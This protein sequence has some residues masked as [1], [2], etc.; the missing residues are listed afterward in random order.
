MWY[1]EGTIT[2]TQGSDALSGTGTYWNVTAN[3]V[4]P[5]MIVIGPDNKLYEIK[6]VI[7]DT[8]LILAEPYTG[9]TQTD[10]PCR[11]IT[12][13]EGDLTQ[14]SARFTAL[15]TRMSADSK[16]MR[17]WLTAVDEVTLEREDGT[18]VTVKSLTQIVDEHN[19]NQKWYTDNADVI[20]AAGDKAREA[21]ASAAAAAESANTA[22]TKATEAS[23]SAAAAAASENA[24]GASASAA[25]TSETNAESFKVE[26][27]A[28]AAT[29][30]TKATE[31]GESA[32][33]AAASKDAA[34]ASETQAATSASEASASASAASDSAAAAKTSETNAS[35]S[36]QAAAGSAADA[37]ASKNA[38]KESETHA[39]SSAGESAASA[40]A[41]KTSETNADASQKAAAASESAAAS[42]ANAASE[43]ATAA[44]E[45]ADAAL[46]SKNAAASSEQKAKTS[47][48]NAKASET[49]ASES[50]TAAEAS[51]AAAQNSEA[52]AVESAAAAAGSAD[53]ASKSATAAA[54]SATTATEKANVASEQA[55]ASE[56]SA[57]AAKTSETN[58]KS[59]ETAA[60]G[61]AT[62]A[63]KSAGEAAAS[64]TTA[65]EAMAVAEAKAKEA[66]D[67]AAL[68]STKATEAT[69]A[70]AGAKT[71]ELNAKESETKAYEYAQNAQASVASVKWKGTSAEMDMATDAPKWVKVS[72]ARMPQST[73][74]VYI[75]VIG[76][77][78]YE[79]GQP[80][81]AAMADIV[82]RTAAG[83]PKSLNAVAYRT[84]D[85]AVLTV[86]T[87]NTTD[88]NYDIYLKA[89]AGSQKLVVN[90]QSAGAV[91]ETLE[92][93]EVVDTLP[94]D[95]VEGT[96]YH[97]VISDQDGSI[98][99]SL[100]GNASTAT[101]LQT[102]RQIGGVRFDGSADINLPGVNIQGDQNTTGNAATA[103]KLQTPRTINSVMFDGSANITIPTLVSRGR[104]N[105]LASNTQGAMPGI[106][107][108]EAYNNSYPTA[109]GNVIHLK[110]AY[111]SGEGELLVG[112]SGTSG[113]H[114]PVYVR[115][116]RDAG[117]ANWSDWAQV[118]T[119]AHKP[120]AK[121]VGAAQAFSASYST[122]AGN[123]TTAEFIAW[124]KERGAF[125]V[126]YWMM[127]GSWSYADN[128]II[129]DTGVGNICLA[130]AVI[131]V[132]GT[133]GAM[134]IRVT[135]PTTTTGGGIACAQF[136]YINHGSAYAPAWRRDYNTALKPTAADVGALPISGGT[137]NGVLT[138]Q[139]VSQP[140]KTPGGGI[141]AN[142]GNLYINKSGF[143]GWIDALFMKNSGGTMS[144]P[145]KIRSTDG[146]RIYDAAYGM[147]FRRSEN[148][149]YLIPTA[150]DQ[151][152]NGDIGSLRPFYVDLT[153]GRVTMGNGAVVNGGLGLGVV[154]GLGG[155][156]I[157]LGDNDTGFKQNGDGILDVYANSAHV[158][159]FISSTLQSLKP[160][161]VTGDITSSAWIYANRFSIN[162]G[163]GAWIDMRNQNV[164]FGGNAVSTS[165][166]QALLR[167]DHAD[168]KFFLGGLGN[169]QFGFYMINNSRTANGTDANAYLQNDGT[170]VC[171]GNG[172]FNDVYIRSDRRSKRN[173]RK[174][175]RALD[176]LDRIEGVLY[177]IQVCD[178]YEQS[179]GLIAQD[180]QNVQPELVT[181]DHND[182]SGEPRLRLNY[183]G[184]IGMLVEA[185][186]ELREEVR[187]LKAR[188]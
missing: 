57:A 110:G 172:S 162:S 49:A 3:G 151:G 109:Y 180:V 15:M 182:Q 176:K 25:K 101:V 82:L 130:G 23:Q 39:A 168:R 141:L 132:L 63:A 66:S 1:R 121:D 143:A 8:S 62:A 157:V 186:K 77:A 112:W 64:A 133:E 177:E 41:A 35:A 128:K 88:D 150:K 61:S 19:A 129:T 43:S 170:W 104:V 24:A 48:T 181:V 126:P 2:F 55:T 14:F 6:R 17:T 123:W 21:A 81:L 50:A 4:L 11:I 174:I 26:A 146:L 37:L 38:A 137:M 92:V 96:V 148:N 136:T 183:N 85:S 18:E 103:T 107:M 152:E 154:N 73:S 13:Y 68:A 67:S 155:N 7:S 117:D 45:S 100:V 91:V 9:E 51:K 163:S 16:T 166:A 78:G 102:A 140:L 69:D 89:G 84:M 58:A 178:R 52:H 29:A 108:Y 142:D 122:G 30:S 106:Q 145:L 80:G 169:S 116:R 95:A 158:F 42:S 99:G 185:V 79:A 60:E 47:E 97:R 10:V 149:F 138:L 139:N 22:S 144:G 28:S 118:Y 114:A 98:T 54:D 71:S 56:A 111:A 131:E 32:T 124:L 70:A 164:I 179:G 119:T 184:V 86:A 135:T 175:E 34:K 159:R 147:I 156:S 188:M 59:A 93:L 5:G 187:E 165:S 167:Q 75:E 90:L 44:G 127:K 94:E 171:G 46:A 20:N 65:T 83:D 27:A 53:A 40:A 115:S 33:S 36:E 31:A 134:T 74:T 125:E 113:A 161:S 160:L 72:T 105:A 12:T 173:I 76:G 153:N 87:V 120:T